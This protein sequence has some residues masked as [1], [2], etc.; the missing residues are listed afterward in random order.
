MR[1]DITDHI[2]GLLHVIE[3]EGKSDR[4][5]CRC[6]CGVEKVVYRTN[7]MR[8]YSRSCG[9]MACKRMLPRRREA[10]TEDNSMVARN[11]AP[12]ASAPSISN[13]R[14]FVVTR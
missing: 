2:F 7:L 4:W 14:H 12:D 1:G 6:Q 3:R 9:A 13:A 11:P 8:G 10:M 5:R